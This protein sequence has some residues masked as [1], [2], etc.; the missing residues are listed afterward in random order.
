MKRPGKDRFIGDGALL[1][2]SKTGHMPSGLIGFQHLLNFGRQLSKRE[3]F[4]KQLDARV[5]PSLMYDGI[6]CITT[7]KQHS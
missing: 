1:M 5:E 7:C 2:R 6:A 4:G 3:W